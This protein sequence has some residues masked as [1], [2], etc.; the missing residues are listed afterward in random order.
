[1]NYKLEVEEFHRSLDMH[2]LTLMPC[3]D[4]AHEICKQ[5]IG[6]KSR[7]YKATSFNFSKIKEIFFNQIS[8][9][10]DDT[11]LFYEK[12][13]PKIKVKKENYRNGDA[14]IYGNSS[15]QVIYVTNREFKD[16]DYIA[17]SHEYGHVP[18]FVNP[19]RKKFE[20]YEYLETFPMYLE[21]LAWLSLDKENAI[22]K[23]LDVRLDLIKGEAQNFFKEKKKVRGNGSYS[24]QYYI[25]SMDKSFKYIKSFEY[26]L[27]LIDRAHD[28]QNK[29]NFELDKYVSGEK[30][31]REL[32]DSLEIDTAG[33]K[34]ILKF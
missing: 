19:P 18:T 3:E 17:I 24:D 25:I 6:L 8:I 10:G 32:K 20:Y 11:K 22:N 28:D 13:F 16:I 9:L 23:F 31:M 4:D 29:V 34:K 1:M 12:R 14:E 30:T 33:C 21:Y 26:A 27:Q 5:L 2:N 15:K 7:N